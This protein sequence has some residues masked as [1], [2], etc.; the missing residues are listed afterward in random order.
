MTLLTYE[1]RYFI[2]L[3]TIFD[4]GGSTNIPEFY[5][6]ILEKEYMIL[7]TWDEAPNENRG[8][9]LKWQIDL[10]YHKDQLGGKGY[11]EEYDKSKGNW[12]TWK[13]TE[14]GEQYLRELCGV[15]LESR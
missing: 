14:K 12:G 10:A 15:I 6:H 11:I 7:D 5:R 9:Q 3:V 2:V 4:L 13:M 8:G 1:R